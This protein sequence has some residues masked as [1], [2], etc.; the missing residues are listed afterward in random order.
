M[1]VV[2]IGTCINFLPLTMTPAMQYK[3]E[4]KFVAGIGDTGDGPK[5]ANILVNF[6]KQCD[7]QRPN[8]TA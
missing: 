7:S 3:S 8:G 6:R 2:G 5:V 4:I 1:G